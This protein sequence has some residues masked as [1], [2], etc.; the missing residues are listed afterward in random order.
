MAKS[1]FIKE[2]RGLFAGLLI[3]MVF[4]LGFVTATRLSV[5]TSIVNQLQQITMSTRTNDMFNPIVIDSDSGVMKIE[6]THPTL[7]YI[8]ENLPPVP[9]IFDPSDVFI[10]FGR[11]ENPIYSVLDW[12]DRGQYLDDL[13]LDGAEYDTYCD[14]PDGTDTYYTHFY[15][16]WNTGHTLAE[17]YTYVLLVDFYDADDEFHCCED[18]WELMGWWG[19]DGEFDMI[20]RPRR[21]I[22][23]MSINVLPPEEEEYVRDL[24]I[25]CDYVSFFEYQMSL[26]TEDTTPTDTPT[27]TPANGNGD[28]IAGGWLNGYDISSSMQNWV[29][30]II[31]IL[32]LGFLGFII[33]IIVYFNK[34]KKK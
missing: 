13:L 7:T 30:L 16:E 26:D 3:I 23:G 4:T 11:I 6:L 8:D 21:T 27:G 18:L 15:I 5:N 1:K 9:P 12:V 14:N 31:L 25:N 29:F 10:Q 20:R 28:Q 2:Y 17:G 19:E 24:L 22:D 32:V 33:F 34:K